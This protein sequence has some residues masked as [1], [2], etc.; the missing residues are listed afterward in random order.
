MKH[1]LIVELA[2]Q[3][4]SEAP[5]SSYSED[6]DAQSIEEKLSVRETLR[7]LQKNQNLYCAS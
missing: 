6:E 7:L 1:C 2:S 5:G 4:A 3:K